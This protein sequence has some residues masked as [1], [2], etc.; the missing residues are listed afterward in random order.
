MTSSNCM[1]FV[2]TTGLGNTNRSCSQLTHVL[3]LSHYKLPIQV[4]PRRLQFSRPSRK[5][6]CFLYI[7]FYCFNSFFNK[8]ETENFECNSYAAGL[9]I[10]TVAQI[11]AQISRDIRLCQ[12]TSLTIDKAYIPSDIFFLILVVFTVTFLN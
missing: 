6:I 8:E 11:K 2:R 7:T 10:P 12:L 1:S 4:V 3:Y 5:Y 9:E